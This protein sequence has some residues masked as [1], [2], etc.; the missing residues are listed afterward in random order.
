MPEPAAGV[1]ALSSLETV[2]QVAWYRLLTFVL[3]ASLLGLM[4]TLLRLLLVALLRLVLASTSVS[5][6]QAT[7]FAFVV[8]PLVVPA[9]VVLSPAMDMLWLL[10]QRLVR[11]LG[12]SVSTLSLVLASW[13]WQRFERPEFWA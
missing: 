2:A 10:V 9:F 13:R 6:T 7:A 3:L 5:A 1:V 12:A 11:R 4:A 8:V